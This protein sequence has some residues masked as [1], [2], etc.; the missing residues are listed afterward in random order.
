MGGEEEHG[1]R[2]ETSI[3]RDFVP[4]KYDAIER[5]MSLTDRNGTARR[6]VLWGRAIEDCKHSFESEMARAG[7]MGGQQDGNG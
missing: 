6:R 3:A 1:R 2:N 4:P 7:V 5:G